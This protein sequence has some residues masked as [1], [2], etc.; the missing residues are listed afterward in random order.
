MTST[1]FKFDA[2]NTVD[3]YGAID[4]VVNYY[5]PK[6]IAEKRAPTDDSFR[7]QVRMAD[8]PRGGAHLG[9][10]HRQDGPCWNRALTSDRHTLRRQA[11]EHFN[12]NSLRVYL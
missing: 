12:G 11:H 8:G 1:L 9:R 10:I 4:I 3:G 5:T 7:D 6:V 2:D